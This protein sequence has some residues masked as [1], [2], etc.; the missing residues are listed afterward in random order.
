MLVLS[1]F[2]TRVGAALVCPSPAYVP[3]STGGPV[4]Y[5]TCI[6]ILTVLFSP[7]YPHFAHNP[8]DPNHPFSLLTPCNRPVTTRVG[9]VLAR[10]PFPRLRPLV[11]RWAGWLQVNTQPVLLNPTPYP[12]H[13]LTATYLRNAIRT[14]LYVLI[15]LVTTRVGAAPAP[16]PLIP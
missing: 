13:P 9:A 4:G 1:L 7:L 2:T 6:L 5:F 15:C 14:M 11:F 10:L 12:G 8:V 3:L 16:P